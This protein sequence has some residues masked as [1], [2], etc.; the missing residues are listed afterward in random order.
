[1]EAAKKTRTYTCRKKNHTWDVG[2]RKEVKEAKEKEGK[3]EREGRRERE[4]WK[5]PRKREPTFRMRG[6]EKTTK[7]KK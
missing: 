5:D 2:I 7:K 6:I 1:M 3:K 4:G